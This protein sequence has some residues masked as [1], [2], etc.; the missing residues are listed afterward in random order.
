MRW[1]RW[2]SAL[3]YACCIISEIL[4]TKLVAKL[5]MMLILSLKSFNARCKI[6]F[7]HSNSC[8]VHAPESMKIGLFEISDIASNFS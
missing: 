4:K 1:L 6:C 7:R 5:N 3:F 8:A 2:T